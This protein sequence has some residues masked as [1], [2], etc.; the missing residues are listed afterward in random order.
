MEERSGTLRRVVVAIGLALALGALLAPAAP[1]ATA[2][3]PKKVKDTTVWLC[4]P[5]IPNNPCEPGFDTTLISPSGQIL[6]TQALKADKKRKFDCFY[7]YPTVS[8]DKTTNSDLSI[9]PEE[10]SIALYQAARYGLHCRVFAP[11]YRQ[12]TLAALFAGSPIPPEAAQ[13]AYGDVLAAWK[14]YLRKYNQGRGVVLIGHSQGT[15]VLRALIHR[16]VD[17]K[18]KVRKR[19]ISAILLGGN[20]TVPEGGTVGGDF[21]HIPACRKAKQFGCVIAFSTFNAPVPPDSKFGRPNSTAPTGLPTTGDVLCTNPAALRGG[22]AL[23]TSVFPTAPFA[24]GTTIGIATQAVGQPTPTGATT[25]WFQAQAY[26]GAC[27]SSNDADVLE[28][29]SV[30]GAPNLH[31]VPDAT[32]GLHLVDANIALGN[33]TDDIVA[34]GKAW[35]KANSKP[36]GK[37]KR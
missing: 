10:R 22:S 1:A 8:D 7:V 25:P 18:K 27:D 17:P 13:L 12:V 37:K 33:L 31:A 2:K 16:A 11:M 15:F 36:K 19:L 29:S 32:W 5:G 21:K 30:G 14:T 20:V 9:D 28:I 35:L 24:P 23:L 4:K 34:E 26:T 3:K 6:G